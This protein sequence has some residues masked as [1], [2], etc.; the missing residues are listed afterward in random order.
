[1]LL[2]TQ[3][4]PPS[5]VHLALIAVLAVGAVAVASAAAS[6][7]LSSQWEDLGPVTGAAETTIHISV[8]KNVPLSHLA[9]TVRSNYS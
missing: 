5:L 9:A 7:P 8:R 2:S 6:L 4:K 1:M 3:L